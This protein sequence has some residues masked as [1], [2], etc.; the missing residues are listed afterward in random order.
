MEKPNLGKKVFFLYPHSVVQDEMLQ[1][2]IAAEIE[3]A[4]LHDHSHALKVISKFPDSILFINIEEGQPEPIW[5]RFITHMIKNEKTKNV[6]IGILSYNDNPDLA[7]KYLIK[8]GI[9]CGFVVLRLGFKDSAKIL[10]KTLEANEVRGRRAHIRAKCLEADHA[11]CNFK[12]QGN[13]VTGKILDISAAGFACLV[14]ENMGLRQGAFLND[15]QLKLST[16]I[17]RVAGKLLGNQTDNQKPF[18]VIF[19]K[20]LVSPKEIQ[21]IRRFI[22]QHT[23]QNI[24]SI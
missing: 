19:D 16:V 21:K 14:E 5:E 6:R 22:Y 11:T 8:I 4:L 10:L 3:V 15:I 24:D 9:H 18:V 13:F 2:F 23:Q 20:E 1:L 12:V 17:C 7:E